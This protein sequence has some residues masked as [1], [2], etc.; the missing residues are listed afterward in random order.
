MFIVFIANIKPTNISKAISRYLQFPLQ[1][2]SRDHTT[3]VQQMHACACE[4]PSCLS[5]YIFTSCAI[6]WRARRAGQ[7]T[8]NEWKYTA[9]LHIETSNKRFIIQLNLFQRF[10]VT[11]KKTTSVTGRAPA[12][13]CT[14]TNCTISWDIRTRFVRFLYN[15]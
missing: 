14:I 1:I 13:Y 5:P 2:D 7:N 6:F 3:I 10:L 8:N 4:I 9:I 12:R 15:N 11:W